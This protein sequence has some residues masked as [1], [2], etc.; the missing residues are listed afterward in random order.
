MLANVRRRANNL[1]LADIVVL[2][3]NHLEKVANVRVVVHHRAD[4][5]HQ[6]NDLLRHPVAGRRFAAKDG[7]ARLL[8][9]AFLQGH[10]L[11]LQVAV[12]DAKDVE[13]LSLV[14]VNSLHLNVK[15]RRRVHVNA[16]GRLDQLGQLHLVCVL[17][18]SPLLAEC[19]VISIRLELAQVGEVG[20]EAVATALGRNELREA[21]VGLVQPSS[22]RN[23]VGDI[24]KLVG[25]INGNKV[26]ENGR[27]DEVGVQLGNT[28]DL[29]RTYNGQE[30]HAD[31][32]GLRLLNNRDAAQ[33]V[34]VIREGLF[35]LLQEIQ[36]NVK[37]NLEVSG[38]Q[39]LDQADGPLLKSLG[40]DSV[41]GVAK[42]KSR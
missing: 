10:R 8:L 40:E 25:P 38:E 15:E 28:V 37:N 32:L 29:V 41:V 22:R 39:V 24:G 6:V 33:N 19:L 5:I 9:L 7:H 21:R 34:A 26:L 18:L 14:L 3:E 42:L 20:E 27:L 13:L 12:D 35:H 4:G 11:E 36:I 30:G 16:R 31:H 1:G 2:E 17:D 23:A